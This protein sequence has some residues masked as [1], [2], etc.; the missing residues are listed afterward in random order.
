M[1]INSANINKASN[2]LS[3]YSLNTKYTTTCDV[4]NP[5]LGLGQTQ[6]CSVITTFLSCRCGHLANLFKNCQLCEGPSN[7]HLYN[8]GSIKFVLSE[9]N[10]FVIFPQSPMFN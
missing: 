4:G 3:S 6:K 1:V 2:H 8:L 10:P 5:D 7:D 9:I